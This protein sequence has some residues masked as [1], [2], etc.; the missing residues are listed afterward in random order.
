M[1]RLRNA[2]FAKNTGIVGN[3]KVAHFYQY[4]SY[5]T[6]LLLRILVTFKMGITSAVMTGECFISRHG[7]FPL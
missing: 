7:K 2:G 6:L 1:L 4:W 3:R 5:L